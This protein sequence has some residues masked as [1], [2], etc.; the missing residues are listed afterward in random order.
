MA[1]SETFQDLKKELDEH[2]KYHSNNLFPVYTTETKAV[3]DKLVDKLPKKFENKLEDF[4]QKSQYKKKSKADKTKDID[5]VTKYMNWESSDNGKTNA[6]QDYL[7][8]KWN[9][10]IDWVCKNWLNKYCSQFDVCLELATIL[11]T[12][13]WQ[14]GPIYASDTIQNFHY[15]LF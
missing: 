4:T 2:W 12:K 1:S 11:G 10:K 14:L 15:F 8:E 3:L 5:Q 9:L 6:I 7:V 13:F